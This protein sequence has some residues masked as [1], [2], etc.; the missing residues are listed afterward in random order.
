MDA[1]SH[2]VFSILTVSQ[3]LE[4]RKAS[5]SVLLTPT[6]PGQRGSLLESWACLLFTLTASRIW[7]WFSFALHYFPT[8]TFWIW[9]WMW[10]TQSLFK[11][12]KDHFGVIVEIHSRKPFQAPASTLVKCPSA[13]MLNHCQLYRATDPDLSLLGMKRQIPHM[14]QSLQREAHLTELSL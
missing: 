9:L 3:F 2:F 12:T 13:K 11:K 5:E 1:S 6:L 8:K 14:H 7:V 10:C 4:N